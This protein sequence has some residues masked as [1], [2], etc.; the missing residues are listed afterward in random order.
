MPRQSHVLTLLVGL[1]FSARLV[2]DAIVTSQA[3]FAATIAEFFIQ[4]GEVRVEL[5]IGL[6]DLPAFRNLMPDAIYEKMGHS[7]KPLRERLATFFGED[8]VLSTESGPLS[9]T[10]VEMGP[11][12]R[13]RRDPITGEELAV[14][15]EDE[16]AVI[17]VVLSYSMEGEPGE[18]VL[19]PPR[20]SPLPN[21]GF[22]VY[23][24]R[25]AVNDFRYLGQPLRLN[26]DWQDP[27][28]SAF[29]QRSLRRSYFAPMSG[30]LYVEPFEVRKEI[31][32]RPKDMQRWVDLG[33]EGSSVI[34]ADQRG[35]VLEKISGFLQQRQPVTI[36]GEPAEPILDRANFLSRT[37]TNSMVVEPGIDVHL[38]SAVVGVIFVY[39]V[40][41]LPDKA[42]M[43]WDMFDERI[44]QVPAASV[45]EAGPFK[46]LLDPEW[47]VLEWENF[48]RNPTIPGLIELPP[49]PSALAQWLYALRWW[50]LGLV[51]ISLTLWARS[52]GRLTA[53]TA[54]LGL[55]VLGLSFVLGKP[56]VPPPAVTGQVVG[57]LL[58]NVYQSFDYR[59]ENDIYDTLARSVTGDLLTDIYL[60]TRQ[61]LELASQGGARAKVKSVE[62]QSLDVQPADGGGGFRADATW[63]VSGS[64]GHWGHVHTRNTQYQA[65]LDI[66]VVDGRWKLTDMK[67]LQEQRL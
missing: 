59:R 40:P 35:A 5:E 4:P 49:P 17:S 52:Q 20:S 58:R 55:V 22:V 12:T 8:L 2:A 31:I 56:L 38:D 42:T 26:L 46:A 16:E 36:N 7:P 50:A 60:E 13:I 64:V 43:T 9:G 57:D 28:Y 3:M 51:V 61:S 41:A 37:L 53:I 44:Q 19:S 54:L 66:R 48:I 45:D 27:W 67:V 32:V 65:E 6:Q 63:N 10:L 23:H 39:P 1:L 62:M 33:L 25:V 24:N 29:E 14:A 21:I 15:A 34:S 30:F 18:L 47:A 11:R